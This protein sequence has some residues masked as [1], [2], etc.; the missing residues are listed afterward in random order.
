MHLITKS[1][2]PKERK[3]VEDL[4]VDI[5]DILETTKIS[6]DGI[7]YQAVKLNDEA[8]KSGLINQDQLGAVVAITPMA[9]GASIEILVN[10][11][12]KAGQL[13]QTK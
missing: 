10:A 4:Q 9:L 6:G 3:K 12:F 5:F 1:L 2:T 13:S 11:A 7:C 8:L